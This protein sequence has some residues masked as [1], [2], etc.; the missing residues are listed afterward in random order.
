MK[1]HGEGPGVEGLHGLLEPSLRCGHCSPTPSL[2]P[3]EDPALGVSLGEDRALHLAELGRP[4]PA[5]PA[6]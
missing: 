4:S 5:H 3:K 2:G 6:V 1:E